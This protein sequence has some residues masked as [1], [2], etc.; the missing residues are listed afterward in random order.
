MAEFI[1]KDKGQRL[2]TTAPSCTGGFLLQAPKQSNKRSGMSTQETAR[3][4]AGNCKISADVSRVT[5]IT[6]QNLS[7]SFWMKLPISLRAIVS[8]FLL[9]AVASNVWPL[10]LVT[11]GMPLAAIAE[12]IFL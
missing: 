5:L 8:G 4:S 11:L 2:P 10:L 7:S 1:F 6:M 9:A 3:C 12:A